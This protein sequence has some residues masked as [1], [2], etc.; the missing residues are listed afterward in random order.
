MVAIIL[1][2]LSLHYKRKVGQLNEVVAQLENRIT[3]CN[4]EKRQQAQLIRTYQQRSEQARLA[5]VKAQKKIQLDIIKK[6][7][8]KNKIREIHVDSAE[9]PPPSWLLDQWDAF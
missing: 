1:S 6:E 4:Q 2:G 7:H 3:T 5:V 8:I 9:M